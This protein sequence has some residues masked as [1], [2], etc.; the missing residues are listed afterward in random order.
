MKLFDY[1]KIND[2][3]EDYYDCEF[4]LSITVCVNNEDTKD[5][6]TR[7]CNELYKKVEIKNKNHVYWSDLIKNNRKIFKEFTKLY[8]KNDY[9]NEDD[10][11]Y[12]WLKELDQYTAGNTNDKNYINL[13]KLLD[14]CSYKER[15]K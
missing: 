14:Q 12:E 3:D 11:T 7:F 9:S 10:F 13:I 1:L 4:D 2:A 15:I 5:L 8:W 6:Y